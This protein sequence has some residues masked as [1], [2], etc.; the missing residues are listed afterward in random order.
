MVVREIFSEEKERFDLAAKHPLQTFEW[1]EFREKTGR[2][3]VRA[4]MFENEK[5]INTIQFS[6][7]PFP[8]LGFKVG[9]FPKGPYPT[10]ELIESLIKFGKKNNCAFI[11]LEPNCEIDENHNSEQILKNFP[12]LAESKKPMFTKY[13]Y[14]IDLK[15]TPEELMAQM[16]EKTRYNVRLSEKKGVTVKEETG[17][18]SF[19]EY[20]T[21][22]QETAARDH[23]F[24]HN[25]TYHRTLW[26]TLKGT[27]LI[28]LLVAR[29]EGK[30]LVA[31]VLFVLK[32]KLYYAYG[33]SS[34]NNREVMASNL[35]YFEA[36]KF[37]QRLGL[38]TFDLWGSLGPNPDPKDSF[39]GFHRFKEGYGG[40]LVEFVGSYDLVIDKNL[41][42]IYHT[43]DKI[44]WSLL[45]FKVNHKFF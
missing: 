29:Y 45:N 44:R 36:M 18:Q 11:Q 20:L 31:W 42:G 35:M 28:R 27:G 25:Q 40:R 26:S 1:G 8:I 19:A 37:G 4:G 14:Y 5:L 7:H 41:Y 10:K 33:A 30:P 32:D 6:L 38:T 2:K 17:D 13:T 39:Y 43:A 23:F 12:E 16:K 9:Y 21:L 34:S 3:I 15:K 22:L 24:A